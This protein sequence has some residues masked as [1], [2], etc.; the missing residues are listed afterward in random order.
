[1]T[2][3]AN[4]NSTFEPSVIDNKICFSFEEGSEL[5]KIVKLH[6]INLELIE[7]YKQQNQL[8]KKNTRRKI[9]VSSGIG[10]VAGFVF[11]IVTVIKLKS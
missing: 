7:K 2:L 10:I 5:L 3:N 9:F 6:P 1:V 8:N 4:T 11:G